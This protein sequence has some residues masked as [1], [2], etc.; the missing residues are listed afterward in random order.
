MGPA[1]LAV[2]LCGTQPCVADLPGHGSDCHV[3]LSV[4]R[5]PERNT[6]YL[7]PTRTVMSRYASAPAAA[8]GCGY[9]KTALQAGGL[10]LYGIFSR[11]VYTRSCR[12]LFGGRA[13]YSILPGASLPARAV[14]GTAPAPRR[15]SEAGHSSGGYFPLASSPLFGSARQTNAL[16]T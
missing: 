11:A 7:P 2:S 12:P 16:S 15:R 10:F 6:P 9:T 4:S 5:P 14:A 8:P 13:M 3:L 1:G